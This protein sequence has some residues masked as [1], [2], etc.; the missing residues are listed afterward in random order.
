MSQKNAVWLGVFV[1][2]IIGGYIPVFF[3]AS[4]LSYASIFGNAIGGVIGI[5]VAI[6]V[7]S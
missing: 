3:G 1:G 7:T 6:K 5:F 2:S 4:F